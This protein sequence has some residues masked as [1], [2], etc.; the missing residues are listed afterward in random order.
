MY[1]HQS[2]EANIFLC[3]CLFSPSGA[4]CNKLVKTKDVGIGEATMRKLLIVLLRGWV[5][6]QALPFRHYW[7]REKSVGIIRTTEQQ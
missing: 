6:G 4:S 2:S 3:P 5:L 1:I 7:L